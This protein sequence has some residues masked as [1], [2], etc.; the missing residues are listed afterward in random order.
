MP[1]YFNEPLSLLQKNA[2]A[3][4]Y[5]EYFNKAN[6]CDDVMKRMAYVTAGIFMKFGNIINRVK[7]PFNPLLGETYEY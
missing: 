1:V 6:Q 7:K 2:E 4:E 5:K 3:F